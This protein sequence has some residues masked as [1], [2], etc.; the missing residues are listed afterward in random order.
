VP[1][2]NTPGG[3]S[4]GSFNGGTITAPLTI[5]DATPTTTPLTIT[6][7]DGSGIRLFSLTGP[8]TAVT[9]DDD[10]SYIFAGDDV[11]GL[12]V[13]GTGNSAAN[14]QCDTNNVTAST[15]TASTSA[16]LTVTAKNHD[17]N[18]GI[19]FQDEGTTKM[20]AN[21]A[22]FTIMYHAAPAD[23]D[24]AA[25]DC[26]LWFDQTNGASKLMVKAK[27]ADGTVKTAAIALA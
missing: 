4:G 15:V 7:G 8:H 9:M 25:G 13:R 23:G 18:S 19:Q 17:A 1:F 6:G 12:T 27:Q 11:P 2:I 24:L 3:G 20:R 22:G 21:V 10:G 16:G 14:L 5:A 26:A